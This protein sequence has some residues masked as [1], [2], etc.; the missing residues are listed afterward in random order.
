MLNEFNVLENYVGLY[1]RNGQFIETLKPGKYAFWK[2]VDNVKLYHKDLRMQY[3]DI[4]GQEIMTNDR[5]TLR[6]NAI[7]H[8]HIVDPLKSVSKSDDLLQ[9]LYRESQLV[10]RSIIGIYDLEK[11]LTDKN[12][13]IDLLESNLAAKTKELGI[14][15]DSF[16]I[17]DI[18]LP[19][20]MKE[21]M[22][23]VIEAKK[24][25]EANLISR[26]E[27][28]AAMRS[29]VNTA[30]MIEDNP[31]LMRLKELEVLEKIAV[32]SK[33]QVLLGEKG[34]TEKVMNLL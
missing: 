8:Y 27:E 30:K 7:V 5:V 4:S 6:I 34:L 14:A 2:N 24:M 10:L 15:I 13:L 16:G 1:F 18:I 32:N 23:K 17:R 33:L 21:L 19:G 9:T 25:S 12:S 3:V 31:T 26:R 20:D 28:I 29:Q 22:N 11:L